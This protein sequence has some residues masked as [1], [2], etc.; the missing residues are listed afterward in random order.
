MMAMWQ[1]S[2][3]W[4]SSRR[5]DESFRSQLGGEP[6]P[7]KGAGAAPAHSAAGW[8]CG[9]KGRGNDTPGQAGPD[10]SL[11]DTDPLSLVDSRVL[12]QR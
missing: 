6:P 12:E 9:P 7:A 10:S 4:S 1:G 11:L 2:E 5:A 3:Q 8:P